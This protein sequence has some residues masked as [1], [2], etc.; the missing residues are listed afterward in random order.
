MGNGTIFG[1]DGKYVKVID[2]IFNTIAVSY[3]H[4]YCIVWDFQI[5]S[6]LT[7]ASKKRLEAMWRSL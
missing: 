2:K 3:T 7:N 6:I 5:P 1:Y 4:L